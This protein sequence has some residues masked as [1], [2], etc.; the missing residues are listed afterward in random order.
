MHADRPLNVSYNYR[1]CGFF[2]YDQLYIAQKDITHL[3]SEFVFCLRRNRFAVSF[4]QS[5]SLV[6]AVKNKCKERIFLNYPISESFWF[7]TAAC[8]I[9]VINHSPGLFCLLIHAVARFLFRIGLFQFIMHLSCCCIANFFLSAKNAP[10][11][12]N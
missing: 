10:I 4:Y 11:I 8:G 3:I 2:M 12:T 7:S 5:S 6:Y 1:C 9:W